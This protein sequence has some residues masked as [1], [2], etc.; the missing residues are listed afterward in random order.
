[1]TRRTDLSILIGLTVQII[2]FEKKAD[3]DG[4]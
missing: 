2:D 1:M 4:R 3:L